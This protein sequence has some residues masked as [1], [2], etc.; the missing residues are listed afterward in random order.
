[1]RK[2]GADVDVTCENRSLDEERDNP[3]SSTRDCDRVCGTAHKNIDL[4]KPLYDTVIGPI[5]DLLDDDELIVVPDGA[6]SLV[7]WAALSF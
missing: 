1:M 6:L 3:A 5:E 2:T 4:L 7:P